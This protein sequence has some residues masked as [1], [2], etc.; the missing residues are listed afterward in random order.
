VVVQLKKPFEADLFKEKLLRLFPNLF[1]NTWI[2]RNRD[3]FAA[4]RLEKIASVLVVG[5]IA[6]VAVFNVFSLLLI[7][8]GEL[9]RDFAVFR[10]FGATRGFIF[11]LVLLQGLIIGGLG[12]TF[13]VIF[14]LIISFVV[15]KYKLISVPPDVYLVSHV[16]IVNTFWDYLWVVVAVVGMSTAAALVPAYISSRERISRILRND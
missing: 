10:T 6:L 7:K 3:F 5:L 16:P 2:D 13:G 1:V 14:A 15:N 4:L 11:G 12:T 9:K 8:I